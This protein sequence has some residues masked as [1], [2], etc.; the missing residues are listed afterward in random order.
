MKQGTSINLREDPPAA[1]HTCQAVRVAAEEQRPAGPLQ[2]QCRRRGLCQQLLDAPKICRF[3]AYERV[4][5]GLVGGL[6][7]R[8]QHSDKA[9]AGWKGAAC[10]QD[11]DCCEEEGQEVK[12]SWGVLNLEAGQ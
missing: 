7:Q 2:R 3:I 6:S 11:F 4:V 12:L 10:V 8:L 9:T 5:Q 1:A